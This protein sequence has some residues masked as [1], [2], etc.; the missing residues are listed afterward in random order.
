[1]LKSIQNKLIHLLGG[2]TK[3]E[4]QIPSMKA[5][6][7]GF[8]NGIK[9]GFVFGRCSLAK[10]L[11]DITDKNYGCSKQQWIDEVYAKIEEVYN[12]NHK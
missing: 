2:Y 5:H 3:T 9:Q 7:D 1:M 6:C 10:E 12:G 8:N 4:Y 11:K